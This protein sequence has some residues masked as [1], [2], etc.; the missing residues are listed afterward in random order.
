MLKDHM[1]DGS[2]RFIVQNG[3]GYTP[4]Q[5]G[6]LPQIGIY[7]MNETPDN[8][9]TSNENDTLREEYDFTFA[10]E[11]DTQYYNEDY[12]GNQ[13]QSNNGQY[14][15]QMNIHNWLLGNRQRMN[16][17]YLFHDG[18]IIDD[19]PNLQ[20]WQQADAAYQKL[21]QSRFPY[22]V[23]AGNHDVG[24]LNGDYSNFGKFFGEERYA[25]NPWYG[26]SYPN[27]RGHYDLI[28]VDGIDFIMIYMGWGIGDDEIQWMNDVLEQ[29]PE[30]KAILNFHEYLLASG[31]LGEEPQRIH[32]EVV[33]AKNE[34]VC[35]VL[36]G[37]YH[38]AKTR[39]DTFTNEDGSTRN[40][41]NMLFGIRD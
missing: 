27:N 26:G 34:N 35:M 8:V 10:V 21:D 7:S 23:L 28:S 31:G 39:I 25:S 11:S 37:H 41:Y 5:Y 36:S 9:E 33:V 30:R 32:D 24:H 12:E 40:V 2:V 29:Y 15:H 22:G 13:D 19:E 38:N 18:D 4:P 17:Q 3:E 20:E 6:S 16:L 14:Q 1:V